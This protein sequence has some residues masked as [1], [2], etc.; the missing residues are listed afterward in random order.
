MT[1]N[2]EYWRKQ[3]NLIAH[4]EGGSYV[5]SLTASASIPT[6]NGERPLFTSIY[7]MLAEGEVSHFH[8]LQSDEI[9]YY[10]DGAPLVVHMISKDGEY[11]TVKLGVDMESG[12]QP[13]LVVPAGTIF[14]SSMAGE[15]GYSL[16]GCMVS[17]GFDFKD[18]KLFSEEELL[19]QFPEHAMIIE[20]M[21]P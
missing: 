11:S 9:W 1:R 4:P 16:V 21:T 12:Q 19:N 14:G 10:H 7:F 3:L 13:Q 5:S 20:K 18:F 17:P 8:Q 6:K 15:G 2:A